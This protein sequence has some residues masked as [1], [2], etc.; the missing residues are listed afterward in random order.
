MTYNTLACRMGSRSKKRAPSHHPGSF[1][2]TF[3]E[4]NLIE[5]FHRPAALHLLGQRA[6]FFAGD[7]KSDT[8]AE[9]ALADDGGK[10][11]S[12]ST[13]E[14]LTSFLTKSKT[15]D[16]F[17]M[18]YAKG[19]KDVEG[20]QRWIAQGSSMQ[21]CPSK[22][23]AA[24]CTGIWIDL[25]IEN[26]GPTILAQL[27]A[28]LEIECPKLDAYIK[29]REDML[30]EFW[31]D[32]DRGKAK[33]L[34]I[35]LMNGGSVHA[36]EV[37]ETSG[38]DWLQGFILEGKQIR[39]KIAELAKYSHIKARFQPKD[40][41]K[42]LSMPKTTNIDAK[43]VSAVLL[44]LENQAL[45]HFYFFLKNAGI[46]KDGGCVLIF[47]G[48]MVPD[49]QS[50]REHLTKDL[51]FEASKY[52]KE[53][54]G[55]QL[56]I[57]IKEFRDTY[58]LPADFDSVAETFFV[59]DAGDDDA[60]AKIL[61]DAAGDR[62][63]KCGSRYFYNH[64]GCIYVE[65]KK[66][67]E[68]GIMN[69]AREV[70][71]VSEAVEGRT[72]HYSK[73]VAKVKAAAQFVLT[74]PSIKDE[75][76]VDKMWEGNLGYLAYTNGVYS[77]E[78]KRLL[79][80]EEAKKK[81]IRFT[82]DTK[83]AYNAEVD[84]ELKKEVLIRIFDGF[85]PDAEQLK[86][87]LSSL[88]R[89]IAGRIG[90]KRWNDLVG[91]R[92]CGKSLQTQVLVRAFGSFV[93]GT[94]AE[95]LLTKDGGGQ[96][97]AKAQSWIKDFEF[98]RIAF[99]N[100]LSQRGKQIMDGEIIKRICSN[101]DYIEVR[102]NY[103]NESRIRVQASFFLYGNSTTEV[104]PDD[105]L[106]TMQGFKLDLEY[107][108]QSEIDDK[109]ARGVATPPNWRPKDP[110]I[111]KF[112]CR[113]DVMDAVTSII[114]E[115]YT[116]EKQ[117]PPQ[118][119]QDDTNSIKGP[120]SVS[121]EERFADIIIEG[122]TTDVLSYSDIQKAMKDGG[123][124]PKRHDMIDTLVK[125]VHDILPQKPSRVNEHGTRVQIR[126]FKGLKINNPHHFGNPN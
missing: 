80:F 61:R 77:F 86:H 106:L 73:N 78:E 53:Q 88:A 75:G 114:F 41:D 85:M 57:R 52:V 3:D 42:G 67:A 113:E 117:A 4:T 112:I 60:P 99:T 24:L 62:L 115:A 71:I 81:K 79:P 87:Y 45:E 107:H 55:F 74:D 12:W 119:V 47:D 89:A 90:D 10:F 95:N 11:K 91:G 20:D 33:A 111:D 83:R 125:R 103:Q 35:R 50:N 44:P 6:E 105:A 121:V 15:G 19:R 29:D 97:A 76:F 51:L 38:V 9:K 16:S 25:D 22:L 39:R 82:H 104:S 26:C 84:P 126:G 96:D 40:K 54:T 18:T 28:L 64:S 92:N 58:E 1:Q 94:N 66:E 124:E 98:K 36:D 68:G 49:N 21:N 63:V 43:V 2:E 30:A 7:E 37:D 118:R 100:E 93:Q 72:S 48:L 122:E 59:V 8:D 101:G 102:Q 14:F 5:K 69:L 27:C 116:S 56:K 70:N 108:D 31:P 123:M 32:L 17:P 110:S 120:A 13:Q 109:L 34:I 65:D 23:R 46:I